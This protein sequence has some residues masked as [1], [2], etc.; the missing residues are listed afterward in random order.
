MNDQVPQE[1]LDLVALINELAQ[2]GDV[3]IVRSGITRNMDPQPGA[4]E[5]ESVVT[6]NNMFAFDC[7]HAI[8]G[9]DGNLF[10]SPVSIP[11]LMGIQKQKLLT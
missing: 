9:Q 2:G 4:G 11:G 8:K 3:E 10:F 1:L 5:L 6:G 7:F